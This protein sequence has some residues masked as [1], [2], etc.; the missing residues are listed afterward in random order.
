MEISG[1]TTRVMARL[2]HSWLC[3]FASNASGGIAVIFG[4]A[5]IPM[6]LATGAAVDYSRASATRTELQ[7]ALDAALL[8][9]AIEASKGT[10][11]TTIPT[12]VK[13]FFQANS[14]VKESVQLT[15][16]VDTIAGTV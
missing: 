10:P 2:L 9:G 16:R 13:G 12:F 4:L 6:A 14:T 7:K 1:P 8:A 5:L 11:A 15:A 3:R